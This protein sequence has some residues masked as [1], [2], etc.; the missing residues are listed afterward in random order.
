MVNTETITEESYFGEEEVIFKAER[1]QNA[2][3]VSSKC[4][5]LELDKDKF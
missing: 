5:V 2:K 1:V 3:V 4:V